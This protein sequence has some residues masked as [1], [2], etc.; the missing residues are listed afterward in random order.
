VT[1]ERLYCGNKGLSV[2]AE[3]RNCYCYVG[4]GEANGEPKYGNTVETD[5]DV[6]L[7]FCAADG[8]LGMIGRAELI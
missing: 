7:P 8:G 4:C 1:T 3:R 2:Y 6:A 5:L